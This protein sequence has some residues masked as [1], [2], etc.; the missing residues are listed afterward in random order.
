MVGYKDYDR[1]IFSLKIKCVQKEFRV[2]KNNDGQIKKKNLVKLFFTKNKF[3][4]DH[5]FKD[6]FF[7]V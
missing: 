2:V 4:D 7:F 1:Y 5:F 3:I 6:H